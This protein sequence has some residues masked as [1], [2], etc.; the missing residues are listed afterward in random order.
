[1]E[2]PAYVDVNLC[3]LPKVT[4]LKSDVPTPP[5]ALPVS[6]FLMVAIFAFSAWKA[7]LNASAAVEPA[8]IAG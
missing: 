4:E 2:P 8:V 3:S 1:M 5:K 6:G 7:P